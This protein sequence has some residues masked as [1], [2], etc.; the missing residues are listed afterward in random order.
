MGSTLP[1]FPTDDGWPY[2]DATTIDVAADVPDFDALEL[3]G[4]RAFDTLTPD[5]RTVLFSHF[6]LQGCEATPMK[7]LARDF[8]CTRTEARDLL[9]RAIDKMRVQLLRE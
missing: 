7:K 9:G 6:G 4:P 1:L 8:G 3:L 5:E 2:P